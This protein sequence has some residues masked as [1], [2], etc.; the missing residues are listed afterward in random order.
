M[1]AAG[2]KVEL[3]DDLAAALEAHATVL[4]TGE[5]GVGKPACCA[6]FGGVCLPSFF[7]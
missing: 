5:P 3:V 4:L 7:A 1:T 6:R 2:R